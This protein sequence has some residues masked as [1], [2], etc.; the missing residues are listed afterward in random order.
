MISWTALPKRARGICEHVARYRL[1]TDDV[2]W[3][4]FFPDAQSVNTVQKYVSGLIHDGWIDKFQSVNRRNIYVLGK[5]F[6]QPRR[7][8]GGAMF[9]EQT[10]PE[11][12]AILYFCNSFNHKR[13]T[14]RELRT[15][16]EE[17]ALPGVRCSAYFVDEHGGLLGLS[18]MLVDRV[19][20]VRRLVWK[21][22]RLVG[23][24]FKREAYRRWILARRF[25]VTILTAFPE[26]E[27]RIRETF[28]DGKHQGLVPV[29]VRLVPEY[30][31]FLPH[32]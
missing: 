5:N 23:Q 1:S 29:R 16:D 3:K 20:P 13:M 24:R 4:L 31:P 32:S 15:V 17:L 19:N 25:S 26:Q 22:R 8:R 11:A 14:V 27:K 21:V 28:A 6:S 30:A 18:L 9:S 2:L 7:C 10:L 12:M